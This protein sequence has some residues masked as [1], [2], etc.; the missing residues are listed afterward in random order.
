MGGGDLEFYEEPVDFLLIL[1][2]VVK[3]K[4]K[5]KK[6]KEK[7]RCQLIE[8][9]W[10]YYMTYSFT[11]SHCPSQLWPRL[12]GIIGSGGGGLFCGLGTT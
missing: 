10:Y 7:K 8:Q 4:K 1:V 12:G 9:N 2:S 3:S 6:K 5:V 11:L